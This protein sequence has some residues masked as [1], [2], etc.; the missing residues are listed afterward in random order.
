M[1]KHHYCSLSWVLFVVALFTFLFGL[2]LGAY[3]ISMVQVINQLLPD[4]I[5]SI[6]STATPDPLV[7]QVIWQLRLP[8][9]LLAFMAGAGL[10]LAGA[11]LQRVTRNPLADPYLF[12]ISSGA[13]FGAVA[14]LTLFSHKLG[15][16][17]IST[18]AMLG[19][20][21]AMVI[22]VGLSGR[23][24]NRQVERMLLAGVVTSFMF[25]A[26]SSL[27]LYFADPQAAASVLFW[28]LGSFTRAS[29]S[30]LIWPLL[31]LSISYCI[32]VAY[33]RPLKALS[34][35]DETA[36]SLGVNVVKVRLLMLAVCSLLTA[37]LVAFCGGIGFVGLMIPHCARLLFPQ[38]YSFLF[39]GLLGGIFMVWVD[40][41]ARMLLTN[42]ELPI[43]I[44]T[45]AMGS[46]FFLFILKKRQR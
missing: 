37:V 27:L 18:G 20:L 12:G 16:I 3:P 46:I 25:A 13:S 8:R 45:A 40:V 14:M 11:V 43:G 44:I 5:S 36:H 19:A 22:V 35:G 33:K 39:V 38:Q 32:I 4:S 9:M 30:I 41:F 28:S 34:A 15:H 21:A 6:W 7:H 24:V 26:L 31:A 17:G 29:W 10:A 2:S 23:Q 1:T 42:Q